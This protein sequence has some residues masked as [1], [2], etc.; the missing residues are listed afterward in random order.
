MSDRNLQPKD[1]E[2]RDGAGDWDPE[3]EGRHYDTM[4]L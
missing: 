3:D 2:M 1:W 4:T